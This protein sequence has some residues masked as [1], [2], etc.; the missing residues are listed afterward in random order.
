MLTTSS[1]SYMLVAGAAG[2]IGSATFSFSPTIVTLMI[3]FK[4]NSEQNQIEISTS[5]AVVRQAIEKIM[6]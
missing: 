1:R 3:G 5:E 4:T 6:S 2:N